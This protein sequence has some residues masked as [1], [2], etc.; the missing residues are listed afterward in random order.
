M[1]EAPLRHPICRTCGHIH[2]FLA[3][4]DRT[5]GWVIV[6]VDAYPTFLASRRELGR[7]LAAWDAGEIDEDEG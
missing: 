4:P 1:A 6:P 7:F 5:I 3:R 2:A